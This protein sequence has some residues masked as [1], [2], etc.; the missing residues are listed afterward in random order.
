MSLGITFA[1][2]QWLNASDLNTIVT[3]IDSLTAPGWTSYSPT[4]ASSGTS[5]S[6]GNGTISGRYRRAANSDL[7]FVEIRQTWGSTTSNGTGVWNWTLPVT[8]SSSAVSTVGTGQIT[9]SGAISQPLISVIASTTLIVA[10]SGPWPNTSTS[11][12]SRGGQI[13]AG[14]PFT[15]GNADS[16]Q[17]MCWYQ[18]A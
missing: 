15:L 14:T 1:A 7:V 3:Q 17:M 13:G 11:I 9:D 6:I 5:P 18:A 12:N 16:V 4:W 10:N 2:G 8:A